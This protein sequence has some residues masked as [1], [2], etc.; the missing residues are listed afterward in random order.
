MWPP[1][2]LSRVQGAHPGPAL[3]AIAVSATGVAWFMYRHHL[4]ERRKARQPRTKEPS[5][6]WNSPGAHQVAK[7]HGFKVAF[8]K[9]TV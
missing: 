3:L 4:N 2:F 1:R 5:L 8:R 6:S 9:G 7:W